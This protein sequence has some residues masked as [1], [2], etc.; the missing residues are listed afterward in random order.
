M[1]PHKRKAS[2]YNDPKRV[3]LNGG[4]DD[5]A[6]QLLVQESSHKRKA[7]P[8]NDSKRVRSNGGKD[9]EA[10]QSSV[11]ESSHKREASPRNDP[12]RVRWD[13]G[14]DDESPEA[15]T[16]HK[17]GLVHS[18]HGNIYQLKLQMLFLKR[19]LDKGYEFNL[20]TEVEDAEKFDDI[21]FNF[22][23]VEMR[24]VQVKHK[25]DESK[26]ITANDL[27]KVKDDDFSLQKYFTSYC[28]IKKKPIFS[29]CKIKDFILCTN[30]NFD[31]NDLKKASI[32]TEKIEENDD[33]L[34]IKKLGKVTARYKFNVPKEHE[35]YEK[36]RETSDLHVLVRALKQHINENKHLELRADIFKLYH[37]PLSKKIFDISTKEEK[38]DK[39]KKI[40]RKYAKFRGDFLNGNNLSEEVSNFRKVLQSVFKLE[41]NDQF[42]QKMSLKELTVSTSFGQVSELRTNMTITDPEEISK[43]ELPNDKIED[44]EIQEFLEK[45]VFAV[46]QPNEVELGNIITKEIG[47]SS[48]FNLLNAELVSDSFQ[49]KMLD[50][51]KEKRPE[52]R[53]EGVWLNAKSGQEFFNSIEQKVS[54][55]ISVGISV[56]Y[57]EKLATYGIRFRKSNLFEKLKAF[58]SEEGAS[59]KIFHVIASEETI[60]SAINV[61]GALEILKEQEEFMQYQKNDSYIFIPLST[62]LRQK[63]QTYVMTAFKSEESHNLLIIDCECTA[64]EDDNERLSEE[65]SNILPKPNKKIILITKEHNTLID[66]F[67]DELI[68]LKSNVEDKTSFGDLNKKSKEKLLE[69][70]VTFQGERISL[71]QLYLKPVDDERQLDVQLNQLNIDQKT[72]VKL[73]KDDEISISSK[74]KD[75]GEVNDYYIDRRLRQITFDKEQIKK[76]LK[77]LFVISGTDSG[78]KDSNNNNIHVFDN[79]DK[80]AECK[81]KE[82]C[83][84]N[85]GCNVHWLESKSGKLTWYRSHGSISD[86]LRYKV[87][88]IV[89]KIDDIS[90]SRL[91]KEDKLVDESNH[92]KIVIISDTAGMGKSTL[93]TSLSMKLK[94]NVGLWVV[95][96]NLND[97]STVLNK[98]FKKRTASKSKFSNQNVNT[99]VNFLLND[100]LATQEQL[101]LKTNL[102]TE[103]FINSFNNHGKVALL[104]DGFDEI[105]PNY[106]DIVIDLLQSFKNSK[107]ERLFV[108]TRPNMSNELERAL[109]VFSHVLDPL[110]KE[111]QIEFLT[112]FWTKKLERK[113]LDEEK[114][115]ERLKI[116]AR[117]IIEHVSK[118]INDEKQRFIGIPLQTMMFA[119]VFQENPEKTPSAWQSCKEFL[120]SEYNEPNLTNDFTLLDLYEY[121]VKR[122]FYNFHLEEKKHRNLAIVGETE[123]AA[124]AYKTFKEEHAILALHTLFSNDKETLQKLLPQAKISEFKKLIRNIKEA[125][126]NEGI[127]DQIIDDKPHFIHLT[128]VDYFASFIIAEKMLETPADTIQYIGR[129]LQFTSPIFI[130]NIIE[131]LNGKQEQITL[132]LGKPLLHFVIEKY[133]MDYTNVFIQFLLKSD[134]NDWVKK[135][136]ASGKTFLHYVIEYDHHNVLN[137]LLSTTRGTYTDDTLTHGSFKKPEYENSKVVKFVN[138]Q[139][140][141]GKTALYYTIQKGHTDS[142]F[143]LLFN[144]ASIDSLTDSD[145]G[146]LILNTTYRVMEYDIYNDFEDPMSFIEYS[147]IQ[148]KLLLKNLGIFMKFDEENQSRILTYFLADGQ[149][150]NAKVLLETIK[151]LEQRK[152]ILNMHDNGYTPLDRVNHTYMLTDDVRLETTKYLIEQGGIS[153]NIKV[154]INFPDINNSSNNY[155]TQIL[156][157]AIQCDKKKTI[158]YFTDQESNDFRFL[159]LHQ[160]IQN[161]QHYLI[162][163]LFENHK[164]NTDENGNTALHIACGAAVKLINISNLIDDSVINAK[165][166]MGRTPLFMAIQGRRELSEI[167]YLVTKGADINWEDTCGETPLSC[168]VVNDQVDIIN[169]LLEKGARI[170]ENVS[171]LIKDKVAFFKNP[172]EY[173]LDLVDENGYP[174]LHT[175]IK[176]SNFEWAKF[177]VRCGANINKIDIEGKTPLHWAKHVEIVELLLQYGAIFDK[178]DSNNSTPYNLLSESDV[179]YKIIWLLNVLNKLFS[180]QDLMQDLNTEL[181]KLELHGRDYPQA[182]YGANLMLFILNARNAQEK[183]LLHIAAETND[184][185]ALNILFQY[186]DDYLKL[187]EM[188]Q[189]HLVIEQ[190][191]PI[192]IDPID[193][194]GNTPLHLAAQKGHD[195]IVSFLLQ[196]GAIFNSKNFQGKTPEVLA[197]INKHSNIVE[198]LQP[199]KNLFIAIEENNVLEIG[200]CIEKQAYINAKNQSGKTPLHLAVS[201]DQLDVVQLLLDNGADINAIDLNKNTPLHVAAEKDEIKNVKLLLK[202]RANFTAKNTQDQTPLILARG[203]S[204][205]YLEQIDIFSKLLQGNPEVS[206]NDL[207]LG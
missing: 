202:Y 20:G 124:K 58:L 26:Q 92:H 129:V 83:S 10:S 61:Y 42:Q 114:Y 153:T 199:T 62:L 125:Q 161:E 82:L 48:K 135:L 194:Q 45:L 107:V 90:P 163:I 55:L 43:D 8:H 2:P 143:M 136:D 23:K 89:D 91:T 182:M 31:F 142:A 168:A 177:L 76:D 28:R 16:Y 15:D 205:K 204:Y 131:Q 99:A 126:H 113:N 145:V 54:G 165:N 7:S 86:L 80:S 167:R 52:K 100:L 85:E 203:Q 4:K 173:N 116:Y 130:N 185:Q 36:L 25:Q 206:I 195:K 72:L 70:E 148:K 79:N 181:L 32:N 171:Q 56:A 155:I 170:S 27:L 189:G 120:E 183:T 152:R 21:V 109:N 97:Y 200:N 38:D 77:D 60:L 47:K 96:I 147:E 17:G 73:I 160:V 9:E 132:A 178:K 140:I 71:K 46:N 174:R 164:K 169:Y 78:L 19:A 172:K 84:Q 94:K 34:E 186:N 138:I 22:R 69:K 191:Q 123:I 111:E 29:R 50:W 44:A 141:F 139:D 162:N 63:T 18:L 196:K 207:E 121:F 198:L 95:R 118:S 33:I 180:S 179:D 108:T 128:F 156:Q 146:K 127:V 157:A 176:S 190:Y 41:D 24:F 51:F 35:L 112:K 201:F 37:G 39:G 57:P 192:S 101:K 13:G 3:R 87:I 81:F 115:T 149:I 1:A 74:L 30:I 154:N 117:S 93:L 14:Q 75:L 6:S 159:H 106:K 137:E 88:E 193:S 104:F 40:T 64:S 65:L 66:Q 150:K 158:K 49:R 59:K 144:G 133:Y 67:S 53:K 110:S 68:N 12:K 175:A 11:Q 103:L 151:D 105:S 134:S 197:T 122:K 102:E 184:H 187:K 188:Y 5:R 98:E 166:D 119:E